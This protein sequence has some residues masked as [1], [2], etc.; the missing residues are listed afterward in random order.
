VPFPA[1][2]AGI[3]RLLIISTDTSDQERIEQHKA[4]IEAAACFS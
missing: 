2:V 1:N 4:A 3:E